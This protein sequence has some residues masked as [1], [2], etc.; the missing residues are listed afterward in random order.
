MSFIIPLIAALAPM[1]KDLIA[2]IEK[3]WDPQD[4]T[5]SATIQDEDGES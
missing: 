4:D 3:M 5:E 1:A 2:N